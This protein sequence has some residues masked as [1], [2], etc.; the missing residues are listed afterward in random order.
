HSRARRRPTRGRNT[1][2]RASRRYAC[3]PRHGAHMCGVRQ[4]HHL[5]PLRRGTDGDRE[6]ERG[7]ALRTVERRPAPAYDAVQELAQL[8]D[9]HLV[10]V[11]ADRLLVPGRLPRAAPAHAVTA[12]DDR[13][14]TA[15]RLDAAL[16]VA[17]EVID[18]DLDERP[19]LE[20]DDRRDH[21][22]R[23][24]LELGH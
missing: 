6:R 15:D 10:R 24:D 4:P 23:V 5:A 18:V 2:S 12:P 13:A 16:R 11:A 22:L 19:A 20:A 9:G 7:P 3:L 8:L 14:V 1:R 17:L 21:V